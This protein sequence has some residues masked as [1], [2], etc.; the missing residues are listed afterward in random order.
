MQVTV[1]LLLTVTVLDQLTADL[2]HSSKADPPVVLPDEPGALASRAQ[3]AALAM[4]ALAHAGTFQDIPLADFADS[5]DRSPL[6]FPTVLEANVSIVFPEASASF[7][8]FQSPEV[9]GRA[10]SLVA[11]A[12]AAAFEL[13]L[14]VR[15]LPELPDSIGVCHK[16]NHS[17]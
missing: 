12:E 7:T 16:V 9:D 3:A 11:F 5:L 8:A 15:A 13:E 1:P 4:S 14:A 6:L 2:F 10:M 17:L